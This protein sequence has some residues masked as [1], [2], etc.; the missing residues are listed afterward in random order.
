[1][2]GFVM[3]RAIILFLCLLTLPSVAISATTVYPD[4]TI[5]ENIKEVRFD[6]NY[7]GECEEGTAYWNT[8]DRTLNVGLGGGVCGQAFEEQFIT[9]VNKTGSQIED[10]SA[11]CISGVLGQRPKAILADASTE[12]T[13]DCLIGV[14]TEDIA[15]NGNGR[16]TTFGLVRDIN[17]TF[18]SEGDMVYTSTTPGAISNVAAA[19][20]NHPNMVGFCLTSHA[21][22][23]A[24]L[25]KTQIGSELTDEHDVTITNPQDNNSLLYN[26]TLWVNIPHTYGE[27]YYHNDT[28][29][30]DFSTT[31][32]LINVTGISNGVSNNTT[33]SGTTGTITII[34][35]DTYSIQST[36]SMRAASAGTFNFH[37]GVNG[38]DQDKCHANRKI[39]N[40]SSVGNVGISC[41]LVLSAGDVLTNMVNSVASETVKFEHLNLNIQRIP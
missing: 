25:V 35:A 19:S 34:D 28:G 11:V 17:T 10:G 12:A 18:C 21:S 27:V 22:E 30:L 4:K 37:V 6:L 5:L 40:A 31:A 24:I 16:I 1:M 38:V 9:V 32:A 36:E 8:D 39:D 33:L 29:T 14:A 26:G 15:N 2:K 41:L 7:T 23:G 3:K 13:G 20:P